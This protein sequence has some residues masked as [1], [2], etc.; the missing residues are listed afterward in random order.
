MEQRWSAQGLP[1]FDDA[2]KQGLVEFYDAYEASYDAISDDLMKIVGRMPVFADIL[3]KMPKAQLDAQQKASREL[4]K[5]AIVDGDWGGLLESQRSQGVLYA[6]LNVPFRDW[7]DLIGAFQH[8]LVPMMI[9]RFA[10]KPEKLGAAL[11]A[12]NRYLDISMSVIAETYLQSKEKRI[13]QQQQAI[14]ELSTPVLQVRERLLLL[15]I[16]GVL[17]T[18]RARLLTEQLLQAIRGHRARVVVI[19]I[20]G[21]AAVDSKVANHL[22]QTVEAAR[23]MGARV[24]VTGLSPEVATTLVTLGVDLSRLDTVSDLQGG[25]EDAERRLGLRTVKIDAAAAAVPALDDGQ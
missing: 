21:V 3:A 1:I 14:Q 24:V 16:I 15:P 20:T 4:M 2:E 8:T 23:L 22:L 11:V 12:M 13:A 7:F 18:H 25:L 9:K 10:S 5:K 17:D 19:D 6:N